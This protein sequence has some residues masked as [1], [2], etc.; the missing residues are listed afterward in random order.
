MAENQTEA[1]MNESD[2]NQAVAEQICATGQWNG[3]R[4]RLGEFV[5]LLDGKVVAV[6]DDLDQALQAL[7]KL[8]ANPRRGMVCEVAQPVV[9][10]IR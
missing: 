5:A 7:R 3:R 2:L 8:D 9:D 4:F 6:A 10:I 1:R